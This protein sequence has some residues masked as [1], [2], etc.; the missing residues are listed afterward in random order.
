MDEQN[1]NAPDTGDMHMEDAPQSTPPQQQTPPPA[2]APEPQK[3][4][5]GM[6]PLIGIVIIILL[7]ILGGLYFWGAH[8]DK[9]LNDADT[10]LFMEDTG[11]DDIASDS[12]EPDAIE[13]DLDE[14]NSAEFEAQLEADL[15]AL[16][17]EF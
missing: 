8:L 4:K 5:G 6:G 12:D 9:E 15:E 11:N 14:F 7:L 13:N 16:E 3:E 2:P 17:G 1:Y 10:E